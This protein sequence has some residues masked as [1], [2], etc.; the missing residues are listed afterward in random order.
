V[1]VQL[2]VTPGVEYAK[3]VLHHSPRI[4][5]VVPVDG[6][7]EGELLSLAVGAPLA[8]AALPGLLRP[9]R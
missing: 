4:T 1:Q 7:D 8:G 2:R 3:L 6:T 5:D 9:G